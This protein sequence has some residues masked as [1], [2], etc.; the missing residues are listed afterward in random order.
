MKVKVIIFVYVVFRYLYI[1]TQPT[2]N[3]IYNTQ[4]YDYLYQRVERGTE[5]EDM[6]N[7]HT[8]HCFS[9]TILVN[10]LWNAMRV[11][12]RGKRNDE[13]GRYESDCRWQ[14]L[15]QARDEREREP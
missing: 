11:D 5:H 1:P 4:N 3:A 9:I 2:N 6:D 7:I 10:N 8:H 15:E 14:G 12:V 13:V